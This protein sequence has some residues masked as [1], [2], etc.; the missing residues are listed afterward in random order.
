MKY[1]YFNATH[2]LGRNYVDFG[3]TFPARQETSRF[4]GHVVIFC[5]ALLAQGPF[6][7]EKVLRTQKQIEPKPQTK[8]QKSEAV[9]IHTV[10][11][12]IS[13]DQT[14]SLKVVSCFHQPKRTDFKS[15]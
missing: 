2:P 15:S 13:L 14:N 12:Q 6:E 1:V 8:K 10:S 11:N 9:N 5:L 7:L 4:S 3:V